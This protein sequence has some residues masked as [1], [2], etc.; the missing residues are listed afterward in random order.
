[1]ISLQSKRLSSIGFI[2]RGHGVSI[3]KR[4]CTN[5]PK[6]ISNCAEPARWVNA[7]WN[8]NVREDYKATLQLTCLSRVGLMAEVA[9]QV[10]NMRVNI[11]SISTHEMKDGRAIVELT[12]NV[13][14]I[15]HLKNLIT[16][17]EKIDGILSVE[18]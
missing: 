5:V 16:R 14:G 7:Y 4:D 1:M 18:R 3:H 9:M 10:A 13:S 17:I 6:D 11:T 12:V 15:D 8:K 2:T